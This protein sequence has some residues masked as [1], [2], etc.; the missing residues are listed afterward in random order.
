MPAS[1]PANVSRVDC[2]DYGCGHYRG[3]ITVVL[4]VFLRE[5]YYGV[6]VNSGQM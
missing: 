2:G 6:D 5:G 3:G 4:T 1:V